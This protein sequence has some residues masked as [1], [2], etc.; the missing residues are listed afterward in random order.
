MAGFTVALDS[1]GNSIPKLKTKQGWVQGW[2]VS[3]GLQGFRRLGSILILAV[4]QLG[5][6][7]K[8]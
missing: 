7:P 2:W 4:S 3:R 6:S 8:P 5:V 1:V